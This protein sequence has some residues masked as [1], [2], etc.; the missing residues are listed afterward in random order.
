M[1]FASPA[2][3]GQG[4]DLKEHVGALLLIDVQS[5]ENGIKTVHGDSDAISA[6]VN[7]LDGPGQGASYEDTL[8]FPKVLVSQLRKSIGD[9]VLGRLGQG[10][11]KPGQSAPWILNEA[12]ADDIAKAE[13]WVAENSKPTVTSAQAP[14]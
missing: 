9:K 4:I 1:P 5:L 7:V 14:F 2:A 12:S 10:V 6:N 13:K 3:P 11:A 8:I